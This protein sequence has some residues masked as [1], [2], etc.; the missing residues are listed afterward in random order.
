M[1]N[2]NSVLVVLPAKDEELGLSF[3]LGAMPSFVDRKIVIDNA[4]LDNTAKVAADF[5]CELIFEPKKGKGNAFKAFIDAL[6]F[7]DNDYV[8]MLDADGSYDPHEIENMIT[9]LRDGS[10]VVMGDRLHGTREK[11]SLSA[12]NLFGDIVL[13]K[14]AGILYKKN[15]FDLCTGYW[16]FKGSALKKLRVTASSF[17]LEADLFSNVVKY[18]L[19]LSNVRIS[20]R[21]RIGREKI[22]F[23][24]GILILWRIFFN[25]FQS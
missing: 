20:Y 5:G 24:H 22:R 25:R 12:I 15:V 2:N 14:L 23:Y 21:K 9:P 18:N 11:D 7:D 10:D 16:A 17:D 8:V 1:L 3:V 19:A 4:S 6:S 13:T